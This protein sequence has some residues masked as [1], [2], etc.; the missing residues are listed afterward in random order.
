MLAVIGVD[1]GQVCRGSHDIKKKTNN[2][3]AEAEGGGLL[4][5]HFKYPS[6]I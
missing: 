4:A 3:R 6:S 2:G 5:H 1:A